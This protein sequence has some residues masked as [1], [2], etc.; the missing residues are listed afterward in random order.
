M[1]HIPFDATESS[2]IRGLATLLTIAAAL[3]IVS[4]LAAGLNGMVTSFMAAGQTGSRELGGNLIGNFVVIIMTLT[5]NGVLAF[6][7]VKGAKSF[8][9][10]IDT[11]GADQALLIDALG[12]LRNIFWMKAILLMLGLFCMICVGLGMIMVLGSLL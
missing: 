12:Q 8:R 3:G 10:V 4:A 2:T 11:D 5:I 7:M 1:G 9:K 6:W